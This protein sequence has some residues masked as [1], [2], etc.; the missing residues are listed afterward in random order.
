[1]RVKLLGGQVVL[2]KNEAV[3]LIDRAR[4]EVT[5]EIRAAKARLRAARAA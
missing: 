4:D 2:T 5:A 1:L 3:L